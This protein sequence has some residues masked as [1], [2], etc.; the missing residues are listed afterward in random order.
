MADRVRFCG[1]LPDVAP[2]YSALDV[3]AMPSL[4]E[5]LGIVAVEAQAT[6]LP[7]VASPAVP[8]EARVVER[9]FQVAPLEQGAWGARL[10]EARPRAAE[11]M[12]CSSVKD[13]CG[14]GYAVDQVAAF[15]KNAYG[16]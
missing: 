7:V 2:L 16:L 5:G 8:P 9:L 12:G 10:A 13:V 6:G 15:A 1:A 4:F 3:L 11:R 14:R